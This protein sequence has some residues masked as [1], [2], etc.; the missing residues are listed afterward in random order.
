M[1]RGTLREFAEALRPAGLFIRR[2]S[3]LNPVFKKSRNQG[4]RQIKLKL[5]LTSQSQGMAG[6]CFVKS[7]LRLRRDRRNKAWIREAQAL[8]WIPDAEPWTLD[9]GS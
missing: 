8:P 4:V 7:T 9:F 6:L 2:L 3:P 5:S 1:V